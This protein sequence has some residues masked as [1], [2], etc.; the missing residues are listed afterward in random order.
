MNDDRPETS[1]A[2]AAGATRPPAAGGLS[3]RSFLLLGAGGAVAAS[4]AAIRSAPQRV[5]WLA[6]Q[7]P[8]R[9]APESLLD[10]VCGDCPAGCPI[11][12]REVG[13]NIVGIRPLDPKPCLRAYSIPQQITHP[14]RIEV[15]MVRMGDRGNDSWQPVDGAEAVERF[16]GLLASWRG[17][18]AFLL[19]D[20]G[21]LASHALGAL[22][23]SLGAPIVAW[24]RWH[25]SDGPID[26]FREATGWASWETD[27]AHASGVMT[28]G[29]DFLQ[30]T[31][32]PVAMQEA[33]RIWHTVGRRRE[34][35]SIGPRLDLTATKADEWL[36]CRPGTEPLVAEIMAAVLVQEGHHDPGAEALPTFSDFAEEARRFNVDAA[37]IQAGIQPMEVRRLTGLLADRRWVCLGPRRRLADQRPI[38]LLNALLGHVNRPGGWLPGVEVSFEGFPATSGNADD[39][40]PALSSTD[41]DLV[42]I[43]N[44]NPAFASSQPYRWREARARH[45]VVFSATYS[46]TTRWADLVLPIPHA[47]ERRMH[48]ID[49]SDSTASIRTVEP[50]L[51]PRSDFE[52]PL[53]L[54]LSV[55]RRL[56]ADPPPRLPEGVEGFKRLLTSTPP[57]TAPF[58]LRAPEWAPPA[59]TAGSFHLLIETPMSLMRMTGGHLPYLITSAN[60]HLRR[61]WETTVEIN[62]ETAH[63]LGISDNDVVKVSSEEGTILARAKLYPGVPRSAVCMPLGL[64]RTVGEHIGRIGGNPADLIP[65]RAE[66]GVALWDHVR[67]NV[68]VA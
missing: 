7:L 23:S 46:E 48:L 66:A 11:L 59:Y 30:R 63:S 50:A 60:P 49:R 68:G 3:R 47:A 4:W 54:V 34:I 21:E 24:A 52:D 17:R 20:D 8:H 45:V 55:G 13:G 38:A 58:R 2:P 57:R 61:W 27:L 62:P 26:A 12:L 16:A 9:H 15:P 67:V 19:G 53:S 42:V 37:C 64:G 36:S 51:T 40:P 39:I 35:V 41:L 43:Y 28:F 33:M 44:H 5:D 31:L 65:F 10:S 56:A 25:L 14:D 32:P 22:A 29:Y 6:D 18:T 1:S